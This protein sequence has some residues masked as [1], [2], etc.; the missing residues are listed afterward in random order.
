MTLPWNASGAA[1]HG[2][3]SLLDR[4]FTPVK[5]FDNK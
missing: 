2:S 3:S 4:N 1:H 5:V